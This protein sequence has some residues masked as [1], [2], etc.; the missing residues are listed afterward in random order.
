MIGEKLIEIR[1]NEKDES[2]LEI[3]TDKGIHV[4]KASCDLEAYHIPYIADVPNK[5]LTG[6]ILEVNEEDC[7]LV[8]V[9][10]GGYNTVQAGNESSAY[11][12]SWFDNLKVI[13]KAWQSEEDI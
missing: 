2:L 9:T 12:S 5:T 10:T 6:K 4:Y 13:P 7:F 11:Y 8:I 1:I 3:V